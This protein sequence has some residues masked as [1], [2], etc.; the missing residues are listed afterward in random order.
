MTS[1][2]RT[3]LM[4]AML[5]A[6][7]GGGTQI[8]LDGSSDAPPNCHY[9]CVSGLQC[10][11][12]VAYQR[13][14]TP[15]PCALW[16]GACPGTARLCTT[17]CDVVFSTVRFPDDWA[18]R[19]QAFCAETPV[20]QP[21]QSC[22]DGC[23]PTR[24]I[25]DAAGNVTQQY[26]ACVSNQCVATAAPTVADYLAPCSVGAEY[27][28]PGV[29]GAADGHDGVHAC[30]LAWDAALMATRQGSTI[31]CIGDW[32]CPTGASCDDGLG[33]VDSPTRVAGVCRPGARGAPLL[34]RLPPP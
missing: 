17:S 14:Q 32:E 18:T 22:D 8:T 5:V 11:S 23:L 24:A 28:G 30:L 25:G 13:E 16:E 34:S 6:C 2:M 12:S 7:N 27:A 10:Q 15:V 1:F 29:T 9:D 33:F 19:L 20:A 3:C 31:Y 4:L 21:G 26:L